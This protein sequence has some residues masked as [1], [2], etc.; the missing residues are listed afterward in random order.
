MALALVAQAFLDKKPHLIKNADNL[1]LQLQQTNISAIGSIPGYMMKAD[2]TI[3]FALER[4]LC[5]L[6]MGDLDGCRL[7]LGID[8]ENSPY[9]NPSIVEFIV[10]NSNIDV[11]NDLL[12]GLCKLLETWL[13]EIVFP[14]FRDTQDVCVRLRDYYDNPTVLRYLERLEGSEGSPLAAAAAIVKIGSNA[15]AA[16]GNMKS[17]VLQALQKVFPVGSTEE[18]VSRDTG[19]DGYLSVY[20]MQADEAEMA[21]QYLSGAKTDVPLDLNPEDSRAQ[22]FACLVKDA[23]IK[24][25]CAG[26]VVGLFTLAG[27]KYLPGRTVLTARK[28]PVL[29]TAADVNSQGNFIFFSFLF[30]HVD[31]ESIC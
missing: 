29:T 24:I 28:D 17:S 30:F 10:D 6:L 18:K 12:P 5:A 27:L 7:W 2:S 20:D 4:G 14:R 13:M 25:M 26:V 8:N 21:G 16:L 15:T 11:G 19:D 23:S 31:N 1:F 3:D 22:D 9:R